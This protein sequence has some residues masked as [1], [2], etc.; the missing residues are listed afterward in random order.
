MRESIRV[1]L[2][3]WYT[4][5]LTALLILFSGIVAVVELRNEAIELDAALRA[6]ARA[7]ARRLQR[8]EPA[9]HLE[10]IVRLVE[11]EHPGGGLYLRLFDSGGR[12]VHVVGNRRLGQQVALPRAWPA[13]GVAETVQ[14][15]SG[16]G[17]RVYRETWTDPAGG[18]IR[19]E[20]GGVSRDHQ[21]LIRLLEAIALAA[22]PTLAVA[23][24]MGL[25]L[26]GRALRP[27]DLVRKTAQELGAGDLSRRIALGG[28][29][30][31][32]KRLADT[33][34]GML[35]R[36]EASF[37]S[38]QR[39]VADASHELRTPLTILQGHADL[40]LSDPEAGLPHYRRALEVVSTE[41]HRLSRLVASLLTLARADAGSLTVAPE[42]I[43]L[44]ALCEDTLTHLRTLAGTRQLACEGPS[45]LI[46]AGDPLWLRQLLLNLVE[47]AIQHTAPDGTIRITTGLNQNRVCLTVRDDGSGIEPEHLPHV[48]DRFYR[49]D[50]ARSRAR[51]GAGLGLAI[52]QWIVAQHH[53]TIALESTPGVGTAVLITLPVPREVPSEP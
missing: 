19:V 36:L 34:D 46:V 5:F 30:D 11:A 52:V 32:I 35:A 6:A 24:V 8:S 17:V 26:A 44:T 33:F 50:K 13:T 31:E 38:Q 29:N 21:E 4:G 28:P 43:D 51:G 41:V 1:R 27:M 10:E 22:P 40:V 2:T 16:E 12:L 7:A 25:F 42:W 9:S 15:A 37:R 23:V 3:L 45:E 47:N 20:A 18:R 49:S 14:L 48:L 39:F 53:G